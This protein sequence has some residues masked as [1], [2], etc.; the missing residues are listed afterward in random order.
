MFRNY[1][2]ELGDGRKPG[3]GIEDVLIANIRKKL[4]ANADKVKKSDTIRFLFCNQKFDCI[5]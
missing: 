2:S 1:L 5:K 3:K 4:D